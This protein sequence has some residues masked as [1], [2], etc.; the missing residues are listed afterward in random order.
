MYALIDCNNFYASCERVFDPS[1][2]RRPI[3]VLSNNDGCV[4]A[5]SAEAKTLGIEMGVPFFQIRAIALKEGIAVFSSNYALY[6]DMSGR[7]MQTLREFTADLEVYS[8]DEAFAD[9]SGYAYL[10][11]TEYG[12][13][14]REKVRQWTGIPVSIGIAPTKTLAKLANKIAKKQQGVLLLEHEA[15]IQAALCATPVE[16]IW[17]IGR[18]WARFLES[19]GIQTAAALARAPDDWIRQHLTVVGLRTVHELRGLPCIPFEEA[20]SPK[21]S[22]TVSRS[23][24]EPVTTLPGLKAAITAYMTRAAEKLRKEKQAARCLSVFLCTNRFNQNAP[25]YTNQT[26]VSLPCPTDYTPE[27]IGYAV[28][29]IEK[30]YRDGYHYKKCGVML[31]DLCPKG[32]GQEDLFMASGNPKQLPLMQAL[33]RVNARWGSGTLFY[34]GAGVKRPWAMKRQSKSPSYTTN[35][36]E[37][38]TIP[39]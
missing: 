6:G 19:H 32:Q 8:I 37:L 21:K 14:L 13:L 27:L 25:Q 23:F 4:I 1:L 2:K 33:D 36:Q 31:L 24:G 11:L 22:L 3:V 16:E 28:R 7:V 12:S 18:K 38:P 9:L 39:S 30:L 10:D 29:A 35:W 34:A 26:T 5:R 17:G 20:P 15:D